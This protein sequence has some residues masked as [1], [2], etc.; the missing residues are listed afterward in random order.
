[1]GKLKRIWIKLVAITTVLITM[2]ATFWIAFV[3]IAPFAYLCD[4][5]NLSTPSWLKQYGWLTIPAVVG[6]VL[7][8]FGWMAIATNRF[9][10]N[11]FQPS[12]R[13]DHPRQINIAT[14]LGISVTICGLGYFFAG[15]L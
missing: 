1:M 10:I 13:V 14:L 8:F 4:Y 12:Y 3:V 6:F 11:R 7:P 2:Y 5:F 9:V 15:R